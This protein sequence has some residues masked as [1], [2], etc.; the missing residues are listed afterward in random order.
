MPFGAVF[1]SPITSWRGFVRLRFVDR[2]HPV[3]SAMIGLR[4]L[5]ALDIHHRTSRPCSRITTNPHPITIGTLLLGQFAAC[6]HIVLDIPHKTCELRQAYFFPHKPKIAPT[7]AE[8]YQV[9]EELGSA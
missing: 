1:I 4:T 6:V 8:G 2:G 3:A 9:M 5:R 7:M